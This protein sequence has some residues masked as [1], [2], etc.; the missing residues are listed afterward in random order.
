MPGASSVSPGS[1][2]MLALLLA[3]RRDNGSK[4]DSIPVRC[5]TRPRVLLKLTLRATLQCELLMR[6]SVA[7]VQHVLLS[8]AGLSGYVVPVAS[9]T[10]SSS[11]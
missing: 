4:P 1:S 8:V 6:V 9:S 7:T 2:G 10:A 5:G 11:R 3:A